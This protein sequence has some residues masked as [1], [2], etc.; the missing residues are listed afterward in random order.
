M[1]KAQGFDGVGPIQRRD[2]LSKAIAAGIAAVESG[3]CYLID[4]RIQPDYEGY[5]R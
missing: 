5:P 4:V 2:D 1:A 3:R